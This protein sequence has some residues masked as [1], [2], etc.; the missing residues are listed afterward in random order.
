MIKALV[1]CFAVIF[2]GAGSVSGEQR[3]TSELYK[4]IENGITEDEVLKLVPGPVTAD[5][6]VGIVD[7]DADYVLIWEEVRRIRVE[8]LDGKVS[9]ATGTFS[10]VVA[11]KTLTLD[12]FKKIAKGMQRKDV[13]KLL[14]GAPWY[15]RQ[16]SKDSQGRDMQVCKWEEGRVLRV[17]IKGGRV[18]GHAYRE[19]VK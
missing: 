3:L 4:Q 14:S 7:A 13:E 16:A 10:D 5:L 19:A 2:F 8:F 18:S 9:T 6:D 11:S 12:S 17:Y 15:H 1:T